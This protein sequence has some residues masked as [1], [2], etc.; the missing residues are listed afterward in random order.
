MEYEAINT[1]VTVTGE[2]NHSNFNEVLSYFCRS[3]VEVHSRK[4]SNLLP[5]W[6]ISWDMLPTYTRNTNATG[7]SVEILHTIWTGITDKLKTMSY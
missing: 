2:Q 7:F 4:P 6:G 1:I 5:M 3:S